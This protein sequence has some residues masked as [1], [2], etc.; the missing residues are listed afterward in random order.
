MLEEGSVSNQFY[1]EVYQDQAVLKHHRTMPHFEIWADKSPKSLAEP[2]DRTIA[3]IV[4]S[5]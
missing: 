5:G 2:A 1:C 3:N 4:I